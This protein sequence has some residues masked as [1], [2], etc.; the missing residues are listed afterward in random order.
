MHY[1]Y[2]GIGG[3]FT[4]RLEGCFRFFIMAE[5]GNLDTYLGSY[6]N[7]FFI[8]AEVDNLLEKITDS[9]TIMIRVV[10]LMRYF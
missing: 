7:L 9:M 5:V 1:F 3:Q 4:R 10:R 2:N 6:F 8:M